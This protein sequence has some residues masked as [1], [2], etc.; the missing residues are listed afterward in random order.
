MKLNQAFIK[1]L[2]LL[3]IS[4]LISLLGFYNGFS[5][6]Q[7][8]TIFIFL[9][10]ILGT[11][12]F[13]DFRVS[14]VFLGSGLLFLTGSLDI[15]NFIKFASLDVII[16]LIGMMIA[17]AAIRE[18]GVFHTFV[19]IALGVR[20]VNAVRLFVFLGLISALFSA[21]MGEVASILLMTAIIFDICKQLKIRPAPLVVF[22]VFTT[23]IGSASTLFGNPVGVLLA[24]RGSLS[25][26]DFLRFAL[27]VSSVVLVSSI[28]ILLFWYR[29]YIKEISRVFA[30]REKAAPSEPFNLDL[31]AKA[32]LV[33]FVLMLVSITLHKRIE[34][35]F[36][37]GNNSILVIAPV[38]FA[39]IL[40]VIRKE[41]AANFIERGVDW[42]SIL[43]FMFL[44]AQ[45]GVIQASGI[46]ELFAGKIASVFGTH[47]QMLSA[48]VLFT[49]GFLSSVL[50][51]TVVVASYIP[52]VQDLQS[53]HINLKAL[54]WCIL[55]GACYGGNIT[56]M[57]ST[58]NIIALGALEKEEGRVV[59]FLE[60]LKIGLFVGVSSMVISYFA[61]IY[62]ISL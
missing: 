8:L 45:T 42:E 14:L 51:N 57:G 21:L 31:R 44:F 58:A 17:V 62:F 36:G 28:A 49:S 20:R 22:S 9:F 37:L 27:P 33:V 3:F 48:V 39:G 55:F 19:K 46:G 23:N 53:L 7:S 18:T 40:M 47:P 26:E 15:E 35:F 1:I 38:I 54:W 60:W 16:F 12:F 61:V 4:G 10:S 5:L 2:S 56:L 30:A 29:N 50:D 43:F 6:T 34:V 32:S 13:W 41:R 11:L 24:L 52:V 59:S 25:F